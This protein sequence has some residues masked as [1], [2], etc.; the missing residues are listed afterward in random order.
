M[1]RAQIAKSSQDRDAGFRH[2]GTE[3]SRIESLSDAV[4]GFGITLLVMST[5]SP[6]SYSDL[7][8]NFRGLPAFAA[9]FALLAWLW[10]L[11]F[12]Y[13]RRYGL[14][15]SRF[16]ALNAAFLFLVVFYMY[17]LKFVFVA[18]IGGLTG[19]M[20]R[21]Y[22][23]HL[24]VSV[25]QLRTLFVVY[26]LGFTLV[27]GVV[28]ALYAHALSLR[29]DLQLAAFEIAVTRHEMLLNLLRAAIGVACAI[30]ALKL[31][32]EMAGFSGYAFMLLGPLETWGG[33]KLSRLRDRSSRT[34]AAAA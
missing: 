6:A 8:D 17:P 23:E 7:I 12:V 20:Q 4:F 25:D 32:E 19:V 9:C 22:P 1:L 31:P 24:G 10:H 30:A 28:A 2:R 33:W 27:T 11:H 14:T 3:V 21:R 26:G 13:C 15:D 29:N 16:Y 34:G 18:F 5:E